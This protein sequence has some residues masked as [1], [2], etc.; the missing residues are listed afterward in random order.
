MNEIDLLDERTWRE[1]ELEAL[2]ARMPTPRSCSGK[3]FL[4]ESLKGLPADSG[5][6]RERAAIVAA[7]SD[8]P[9]L[10]GRLTRALERLGAPESG[11]F[12][13]FLSR[14]GPEGNPAP[15]P[16]GARADP[17]LPAAFFACL[18][19]ANFLS[20]GLF[21]VIGA[22]AAWIVLP[23][24]AAAFVLH[25]RFKSR[26]MT[27]G[28]LYFQIAKLL[29]TAKRLSSGG[30]KGLRASALSRDAERLKELWPPLEALRRVAAR[31]VSF[32]G[33][34]G[35]D[36]LEL[37]VEYAKIVG[38]IE[39]AS[40]RK[41][42]ALARR[43]AAALRE[44]DAIAGRLDAA[45]SIAEYRAA[46]D[47]SCQAEFEPGSGCIAA[48]GLYLPILLDPVPNSIKARMPGLVVTGT[49]MSGKSTFL[50]ALGVATVMARS[51]G[52]APARSFAT[53][54]FRPMSAIASS[55]DALG[56]KSRYL[57][58]AKRILEILRATEGPGGPVLALVDEILSGTNSHERSQAA[59]AILRHAASLKALV[60]ACTHDVSIAEALGDVYAL[61]H[62]SD[63]VGEGGLEFDYILKEGIVKDRNAIRLLAW[64]GYP[65][66]ILVSLKEEA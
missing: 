55:D 40:Y 37:A 29:G 53:D 41:A 24:S 57:D 60:V 20:Y 18:G 49:N 65:S 54:L 1:L 27:D 28:P 47:Y 3:A 63:A 50:R 10:H 52:F 5:A 61:A 22:Q 32:E 15:E 21:A 17:G 12:A 45:L 9:A 31:F 14:L 51:W 36:F 13:T 42:Q 59:I 26:V 34:V 44:I 39:V 8:D 16:R 66:E 25:Y 46:L 2:L 64:L 30:P 58:E 4:R 62:F 43:H 48:E 56:G 7:L 35:G 19:A 33:G 23:L 38:L 11:D 6:V